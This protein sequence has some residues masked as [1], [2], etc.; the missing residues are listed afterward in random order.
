MLLIDVRYKTK[1][2]MRREFYD[3][4]MNGGIA[5]CSRG[6]SGNILYEYSFSEED[7]DILQLKEIWVDKEAQ[8]E[9]TRTEHFQQLGQLKTTYVLNTELNLLD[10]RRAEQADLDRIAEIEAESFPPSEAASRATYQWRLEHYPEY[11]FV[12]ES[13]GKIVAVVD[14]IP[15]AED[16]ITDDIFETKAL[17]AGKTAAIL[18]VMTAADYRR[19]GMAGMLLTYVLEQM[20]SC[21]MN[22][23]C[24]TCKEHLIHYYAGFGFSKT[25]VSQSVHGGA[26]W[27]DM[28]RDL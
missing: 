28:V 4:V 21:G 14:V 10:A 12:G 26:M 27:Y 11:F 19:R 22:K 15:W 3:A 18:S 7:D 13:D 9:H 1:P 8:Q 6:E 25:G 16:T 23:A 17:P 20:E 2:G 24:L 5:D